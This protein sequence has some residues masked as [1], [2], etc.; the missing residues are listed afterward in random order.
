[1]K[2]GEGKFKDFEMSD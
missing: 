2:C 1:V